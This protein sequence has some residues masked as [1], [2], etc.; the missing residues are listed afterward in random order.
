MLMDEREQRFVIKFLWRQG[1]G[2]KAI[3]A[4]LLSTLVGTALSLLTVRRWI[5]HLK[6]GNTSCED[7]RQP[8]RPMVIA[9]DIIRKFLARYPVASVKVMS[10]HFGVSSSTIKEVLS[11]KL[12]FRKYA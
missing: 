11:L 4:Q 10:R 5:R 3:H 1:L 8:G 6:E 9:G 12:G 7:A 2:G